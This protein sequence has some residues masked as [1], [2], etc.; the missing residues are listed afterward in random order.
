MNE[1]VGT[2]R[3]LADALVRLLF[4]PE[5]EAARAQRRGYRGGRI[6]RPAAPGEGPKDFN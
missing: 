3:R 2:P 5:R 1:F 4:V 6:K